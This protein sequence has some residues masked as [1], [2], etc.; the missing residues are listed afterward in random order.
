MSSSRTARAASASNRHM[1]EVQGMC[2]QGVPL[3]FRRVG[4]EVSVHTTS[5]TSRCRTHVKVTQTAS[6]SGGWSAVAHIPRIRTC[7]AHDLRAER[8]TTDVT[9]QE[10]PHG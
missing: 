8:A 7:V 4:E 3:R 9:Y 10:E 1:Q 2:P 5:P 6:G